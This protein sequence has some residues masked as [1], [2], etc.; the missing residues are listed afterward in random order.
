MAIFV[1]QTVALMQHEVTQVKLAAAGAAVALLRHVP[2]V[3]RNSL[4]FTLVTERAV[5]PVA[6]NRID[7]LDMCLNAA[8]HF[9][10][11]WA[12]PIWNALLV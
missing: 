12:L 5:H 7:F 1:P 10:N 8:G 11:R 4:Y 2:E 9:S 3:H 6:Q